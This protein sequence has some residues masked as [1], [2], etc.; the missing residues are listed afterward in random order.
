MVADG[1]QP[2]SFKKTWKICSAAILQVRAVQGL[3][4]EVM[5]PPTANVAAHFPEHHQ[6]REDSIIS[7]DDNVYVTAD[8]A[9]PAGGSS[10]NSANRR[11]FRCG[12]SNHM[13]G[14]CNANAPVAPRHPV[15]QSQQY[16]HHPQTYSLPPGML[17]PPPGMTHSGA[18]HS[19]TQYYAPLGSNS[20]TNPNLIPLGRPR[21][22]NSHG[23]RTQGSARPSGQQPAIHA[24]AA[25]ENLDVEEPMFLNAGFSGVPAGDINPQETLFDSGA[26]HHLTGDN[27][28]G[29]S[30][31]W[32]S[33]NARGDH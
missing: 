17:P 26:S 28:G 25:P 29:P 2:I 7:G 24:A 27:S 8:A 5:A 1:Y 12:S 16:R 32:S 10:S 19:L 3:E 15:N 13:I 4:D 31:Y 30:F 20:A 33:W 23:G 11:C 9:R 18:S 22:D 21:T 6:H 14:Q